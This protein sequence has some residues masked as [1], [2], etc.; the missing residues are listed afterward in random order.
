MDIRILDGLKKD[1]FV[2]ALEQ[3]GANDLAEVEPAVRRIVNSVR[4]GGDAALRRYAERWDGLRKDEPLRV[5]EHEL[6]NAWQ[7]ISTQLQDAIS[8]AAGNIRR[9]CE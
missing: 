3:R 8:Q 9:Y 6:K 2:R 1:R 4:R 7:K 5:P